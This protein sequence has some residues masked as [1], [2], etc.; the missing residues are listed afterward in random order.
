ME[1]MCKRVDV[2]LVY[3]DGGRLCMCFSW[4]MVIEDQNVGFLMGPTSDLIL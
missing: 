1:G 2:A 3:V 4:V